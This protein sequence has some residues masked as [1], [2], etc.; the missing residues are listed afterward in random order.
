MTN[1]CISGDGYRLTEHKVVFE[2]VENSAGLGTA[3]GGEDHVAL[4]AAAG[5]PPPL[6]FDEIHL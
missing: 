5:T 6:G 1:G 2:D 3:G 4:R